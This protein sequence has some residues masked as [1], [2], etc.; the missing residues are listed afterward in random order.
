MNV[1]YHLS[2]FGVVIDL[3]GR[4]EEGFLCPC[5]PPLLPVTPRVPSLI[6]SIK[7]ACMGEK[8]ISYICSKKINFLEPVKP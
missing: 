1:W 2:S 8:V 3:W 5:L 7:Y 4:K 6:A